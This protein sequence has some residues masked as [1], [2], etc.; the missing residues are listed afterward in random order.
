VCRGLGGLA[1]AVVV[2]RVVSSGAWLRA[3][4]GSGAAGSAGRSGR[5]ARRRRR[6][7]ACG[8][9]P[10]ARRACRPYTPPPRTAAT[11][12]CPKNYA[13]PAAGEVLL[14]P[15]TDCDLKIKLAAGDD[16]FLTSHVR[17]GA[18]GETGGVAG[19]SAGSIEVEGA[20]QRFAPLAG[21]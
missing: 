15:T 20:L 4:P 1:A 10:P 6:G 2:G 8:Q 11:G 12:A 7:V 18:G 14:P 13:S 3:L 5:G 17:A 19:A 9:G 16:Y 21:L